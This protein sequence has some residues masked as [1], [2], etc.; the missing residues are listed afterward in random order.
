MALVLMNNLYVLMFTNMRLCFHHQNYCCLIKMWL[1]FDLFCFSLGFGAKLPPGGKLSHL[2]PL[3]GNPQY[4]FCDGV[5]EILKQYR[6]RLKNVIII[7][8]VLTLFIKYSTFLFFS[9]FWEPSTGWIVRPYKLRARHQY[10]G[11]NC[12]AISKW[13]P[14]FC[15]VDNNRWSDFRHETYKTRH[16]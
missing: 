14:L 8:T 6:V 1:S 9:S 15:I 5:E 12:K 4:P 2:F 7:A 3:N 11:Y 13:T 16:Y 10:H